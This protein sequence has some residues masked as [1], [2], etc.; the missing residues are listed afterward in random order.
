M[1]AFDHVLLLLSFVFAL[2]VTH[3]LSRV[4][5]LLLARKN[6]RFSALQT[7]EIV[8]AFAGVYA[9]WLWLWSLRGLRDWDLLSITIWFLFAAQN[10]FLC[11]AAGPETDEKGAI[12]MERFYWDNRRLFYGL[13]LAGAFLGM[14]TNY[15]LLKSPDPSMFFRANAGTLPTFAPPILALAVS[16]RWAQWVSGLGM[17][18]GVSLW[19]VMFSSVLK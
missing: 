1:S 6:V 13:A 17:L 9:N 12:D 16:A 7:I 10:Y 8:N 14:A 5:A 15:T 18:L 2:A 11:V 4:G 3:L 19:L